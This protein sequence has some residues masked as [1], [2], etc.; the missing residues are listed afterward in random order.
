[1]DTTTTGTSSA[2]SFKTEGQSTFMALSV[3]TYKVTVSTTV[4][5]K[6]WHKLKT[7]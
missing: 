1:M 5:A 4:S 7:S 2:S 6:D 3:T